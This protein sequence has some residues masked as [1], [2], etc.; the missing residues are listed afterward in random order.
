MFVKLQGEF[1][2]E[3]LEEIA[4]WLETSHARLLRFRN[5]QVGQ[6][7]DLLGHQCQIYVDVNVF[8]P[9]EDDAVYFKLKYT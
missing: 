1:E 5:G 2:R 6:P 9:N 3:T 8:I 4:E 7:E